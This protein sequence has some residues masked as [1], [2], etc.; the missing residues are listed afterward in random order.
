VRTLERNIGTVCRKVARG[1]AEGKTDPVAV[2]AEGLHE[3]LGPQK[4]FQELAERV[5][6]PGV[7]TGLAWTPFGGDILF[8]ES[9]KM[10]GKKGLTLTGRLGDVMKESAQAALSYIR[11]KGGEFGIDEGFFEEIDL[12]IHVPEGATPK[13]GPSA[14]V[15]LATSLVS[16]LTGRCVKPFVA[17]TG[18]ITLRGRVLPVGGIK[19]KVIA[20]K[21]AGI[22]KIF[23]PKE[24]EKDL[25]E[26]P[27]HVKKDLEFTFVERIDEVVKG[28][29]CEGKAESRK[30]PGGVPAS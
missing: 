12:H 24:N 20:A 21:R 3:Y 28:A 23:L 27:E 7:A 26:V 4:F 30:A 13:D 2:T 19:E 18:E 15:T 22:K 8:V 9:T 17:M 29:L 11:S 10:K 6:E 1:W 14:G 25:E 5:S 16:L